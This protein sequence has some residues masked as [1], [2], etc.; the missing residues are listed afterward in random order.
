MAESSRTVIPCLSATPNAPEQPPSS[1][2]PLAAGIVFFTLSSKSRVS[3]LS[4]CPEQSRRRDYGDSGRRQIV[5]KRSQSDSPRGKTKSWSRL[6]TTRVGGNLEDLRSSY[7]REVI[8]HEDQAK[9][10]TG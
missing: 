9:A 8:P 4:D 2:P 5:S 6:P 3:D 10:R 7:Q 1:K